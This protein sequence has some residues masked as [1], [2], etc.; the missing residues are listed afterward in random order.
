MP[1]YVPPSYANIIAPVHRRSLNDRIRLRRCVVE[2]LIDNPGTRLWFAGISAAV[3]FHE[4][5]G[6]LVVPRYHLEDGYDLGGFIHNLRRRYLRP[7]DEGE[8]LDAEQV[9]M[10]DALGMVW[11]VNN[12]RFADVYIPAFT[13]F[14]RREGHLR[15]PREHREHG[16]KLGHVTHNTRK[17]RRLGKVPQWRI[18][19][20]DALGFV[21]Q[22]LE[23]RGP[24]V[25][26]PLPTTRS[27][28]SRSTCCHD[29]AL[30]VGGPACAG[31]PIAGGTSN[32][33]GQ[34]RRSGGK[35]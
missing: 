4:R 14:A 16:I 33:A 20:L 1:A 11:R 13:S 32:A 15:V 8:Q 29:G 24:A 9:W 12:A 19:V 10:L 31:P 7:R 18:D 17:Q 3:A 35:G 28:A 23:P 30:T 25:P 2:R 27:L 34:D 22:V 21:W 6:H 26:Q 5:E